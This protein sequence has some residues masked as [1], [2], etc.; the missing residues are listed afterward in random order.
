MTA[1]KNNFKKHP[2]V[3]HHCKINTFSTTKYNSHLI[4]TYLMFLI[5]F[6]VVIFF[7]LTKV[8][9]LKDSETNNY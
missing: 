2:H 1:E 5:D 6:I 8:K 7:Y 4:S 9:D 3:I